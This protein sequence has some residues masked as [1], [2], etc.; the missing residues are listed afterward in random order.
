MEPWLEERVE[1]IELLDRVESSG[2]CGTSKCCAFMIFG[3]L[4]VLVVKRAGCFSLSSK[5]RFKAGIFF[6]LDFYETSV[7][8]S[9]RN[10]SVVFSGCLRA[11]LCNK[12]TLL[13]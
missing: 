9:G 8:F 5:L 6:K 11:H 10:L 1:L 4:K 3:M 13:S 7:L 12:V 2:S